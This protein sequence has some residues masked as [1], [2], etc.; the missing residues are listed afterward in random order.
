MEGAVLRGARMEGTVLL[1]ARMEGADLRGAEMTDAV[2]QYASVI[3]ARLS[4][5]R[6]LTQE[7]LNRMYGDGLT[8][9]RIEILRREGDDWVTD[10]LKRPAHWPSVPIPEAQRYAC[11]REWAIGAGA[12]VRFSPNTDVE[13]TTHAE[14]Q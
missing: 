1:R 13:C 4:Q 11:W 5:V 9:Q 10:Y 14:P 7:Q 12:W 3:G 6:N 2:V 8:P